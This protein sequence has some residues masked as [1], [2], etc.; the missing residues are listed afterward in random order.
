[1]EPNE[2]IPLGERGIAVSAI[3]KVRQII[4][5]FIICGSVLI[6]IQ[7]SSMRVCVCVCLHNHRAPSFKFAVPD[8]L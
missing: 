8:G 4:H 1:M 2:W 3:E 5:L 6:G 7:F